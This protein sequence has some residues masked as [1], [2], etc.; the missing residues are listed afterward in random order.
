MAKGWQ[1]DA[2]LLALRLAVGGILAAH[3]VQK[4]FGW[5]GGHGP[6]DTAAAFEQDGLRARSAKCPGCGPWR[7]QLWRSHRARP[8]PL[9]SARPPPT[10]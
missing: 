2:G 5:F 9:R 10:P 8:R 3:G 1:E 6:K 4:L 7:G